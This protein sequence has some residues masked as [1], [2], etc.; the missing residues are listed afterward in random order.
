M[1]GAPAAAHEAAMRVADR[2]AQDDTLPAGSAADAPVMSE[3]LK[4]ILRDM[5]AAGSRARSEASL[6]PPA[7]RSQPERTAS[8]FRTGQDGRSSSCL[9]QVHGDGYMRGMHDHQR[10]FHEE[11][12]W[13]DEGRVLRKAIL[14]VEAELKTALLRRVRAKARLTA[15]CA[16]RAAAALVSSAEIRELALAKRK[17]ARS[18]GDPLSEKRRAEVRWRARLSFTPP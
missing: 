18:G 4:V 12:V 3:E 13:K 8:T 1:G 16:D 7:L 10:G 9:E 15:G 5:G 14:R 6:Q 11:A 17:L 2:L